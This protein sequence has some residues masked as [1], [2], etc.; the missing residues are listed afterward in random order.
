MATEHDRQLQST[1]KKLE[2]RQAMS[3][4]RMKSLRKSKADPIKLTFC[5]M[6]ELDKIIIKNKSKK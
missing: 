3:V 5:I 6:D 4:R 2:K 1:K